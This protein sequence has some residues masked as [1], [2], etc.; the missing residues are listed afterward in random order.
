MGKKT[1]DALQE[2]GAVYLNA[3]GGAAQ[4]YADKIT[5]ADGVDFLEEFGIRKP[6][7]TSKLAILLP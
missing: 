3:I 7:G 4:F 2:V 1:L 5:S 6:C